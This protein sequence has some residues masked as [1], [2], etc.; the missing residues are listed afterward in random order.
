[1]EATTVEICKDEKCDQTPGPQ[2]PTLCN[3]HLYMACG[4]GIKCGGWMNDGWT[5]FG[6]V[7]GATYGY[8]AACNKGHVYIYQSGGHTHGALCANCQENDLT[9]EHGEAVFIYSDSGYCSK[10][11][12]DENTFARI[13]RMIY[14][15]LDGSTDVL[16]DLFRE[17]GDLA[18][19][20]NSSQPPADDWDR[21]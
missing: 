1:M 3:K 2:Y 17:V 6:P 11:C 20:A 10:A 15:A 16:E 18:R 7:P 8:V 5:E 14:L 9:T 4:L 21:D 19:N 13:R 12:R